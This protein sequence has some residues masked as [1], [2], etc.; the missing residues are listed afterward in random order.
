[1]AFGSIGGQAKK[2]LYSVELPSGYDGSL[3]GG[4]EHHDG[5]ER[6]ED[7]FLSSTDHIWSLT[8][9]KTSDADDICPRIVFQYTIE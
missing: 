5:P 2:D 3:L 8:E 9:T 4:F 1:M 6:A 7:L